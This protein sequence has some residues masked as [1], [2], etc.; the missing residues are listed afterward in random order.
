[1]EGRRAALMK[2]R[3]F[4]RQGNYTVFDNYILDAIMPT[5]KPTHWKVLCLI[6][7]KTIGWQKWEDALSYSQIMEGTGIRNRNTIS[8]ALSELIARGYILRRETEVPNEANCYCLNQEY[9][10]DTDASTQNVLQ[11]GTKIVHTKERTTKEND[12]RPAAESSVPTDHDKLQARL[13]QE[14]LT[15]NL[16]QIETHQELIDRYGYPAW[17]AGFEQTKPGAR[18]NHAYVEK[19]I[20]SQIDDPAPARKGKGEINLNR[21]FNGADHD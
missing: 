8:A 19:V 16:T 4:A 21:L 12:K 17:L 10:I 6:V 18:S 11:P 2:H 13:E 1:M 15:V 5:L 14:W 7:R 9:E 3:P 20:L